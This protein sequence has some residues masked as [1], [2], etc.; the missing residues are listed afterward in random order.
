MTCTNIMLGGKRAI[1]CMR[2]KRP[3]RCAFCTRTAEFLCDG[4]KPEANPETDHFDVCDALICGSCLA[5]I[6]EGRHLCPRC[7]T[8]ARKLFVELRDQ[9]LQHGERLPLAMLP[10]AP[11]EH[12][13]L[14]WPELSDKP[15]LFI[16]YKPKLAIWFVRP[17]EADVWKLPYDSQH[18]FKSQLLPGVV[19]R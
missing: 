10:R 9:A 19:Q 11:S 4:H 3:K 16:Q 1:V 15:R 12:D 6:G 8:N 18:W 5:L 2:S 17:G 14:F 13:G 7:A